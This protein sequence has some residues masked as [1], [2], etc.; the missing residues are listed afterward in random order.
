MQNIKNL[1]QNF[2]G[3]I[4]QTPPKVSAVK[5]KGE[6]AY[7][8]ARSNINFELKNDKSA[9]SD[10]T[11][12]I[13]INPKSAKAFHAR[14]VVKYVLKDFRGAKSDYKK[15]LKIDPKYDAVYSD[16]AKIK[17]DNKIINI[18]DDV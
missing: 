18:G 14:G 12:I 11:E 6:R 15:A 7:K 8:L 13:R 17:L 4:Y 10:Y 2:K 9:I 5:I 16:F 3:N 1:L